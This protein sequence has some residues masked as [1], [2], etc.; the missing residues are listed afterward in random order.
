MHINFGRLFFVRYAKKLGK[1]ESVLHVVLIKNT[2]IF[3]NYFYNIVEL[4]N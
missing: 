3:I 4:C 2:K 1:L